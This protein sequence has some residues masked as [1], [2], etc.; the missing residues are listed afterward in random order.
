MEA[1]HDGRSD[2]P[3]YVGACTT[4]E[5]NARGN[6]L[7]V[8]R[9]DATSGQWTHVQL[10]AD[11]I[12]PSFLALDRTRRCLYAVHGD[13][14]EI[15]AFAIAPD[16]GKLQF[17]NRQST[18][19]RNPVHLAVDPA[20][21]FV[22]VANHLSSTLALLP[23]RDDGALEPVVDLLRLEGEPGP[24][25]VEQP[26]AKPHQVEPDPSGRFIVVPD[27]GLDRLFT[28][29]I[30][31][32]RRKLSL[33]GV[34]EARAGAGPR[35]VAF[36]P[37]GTWAYVINELDCTVTA[38]RFDQTTGALG[39]FQLLPSLPDTFTGNSRAAEIACSAD[40]RFLFASNRGHDS[41]AIFAIDGASGRLAARGWQ[42]SGGQTPRF[43]ALDPAQRFL[44]VVNEDS[45]SIITFRLDAGTGDLAQT[46]PA[47][48]I[49]SPVCIA[50]TAPAP[51]LS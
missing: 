34:A 41:I 5:R 10:L 49:G 20:N 26:F 29:R 30:D 46:G 25:R 15:S 12:N 9:V 3:C 16:T 40:G 31:H 8:Y 43:F 28:C 32:E 17:L 45:D 47:L 14:T 42:A 39:P 44:F 24:H 51:A 13:L 38:Y 11:L 18:E 7:N 33:V 23:R 35:H 22:V 27:K 50:L 6:G 36:H 21:R 1:S 48:C 19:G 37:S 2:I 4:R